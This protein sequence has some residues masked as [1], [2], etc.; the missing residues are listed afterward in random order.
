MAQGPVF[1]Q[2]NKYGKTS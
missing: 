1:T 2:Q